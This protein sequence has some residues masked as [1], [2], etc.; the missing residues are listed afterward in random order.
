[1]SS[2]SSSTPR[3]T[4]TYED[5][6]A[7]LSQ[8]QS[9]RHIVNLFSSQPDTAQQDIN[10]L[11]IPEM[12]AWLARAG[13]PTPE[14]LSS[15]GLKVVHV[16]GTKGKGSV[17]ALVSGI[18]RQYAAAGEDE[19]EV[20]V[21]T[22]VS[23]HVVDVR[24]RILLNGEVIG[25]DK[26]AKYFFEVWERLSRAAREAGDAVPDAAGGG[27]VPD[28]ESERE[29]WYDGAATKPFY[30]RFLT[31]LAF[32]IFVS[33]PGVRWA[34]VE[35]GIGGEYDSTNVLPAEMVTAAVVTQLGVDHVSMLGDTVPK[36]AWH[37]AGIFKEGVRGFTRE[38]KETKEGEEVMEVLR[39]RA[40]EKGAS[41]LV[42]VKDEEVE[43][44]RGVQG[45]KLE[46]PFQKYNMA[47]AVAAAREH[48]LKVG[49]RLDGEFAETGGLD[50]MP[51]EFEKGLREASL[52]GRCEVLKDEEG[53]EW[54]VDGAHTEDSLRGVGEWFAG[55]VR[56]GEDKAVR[57]LV[58]NQQDRDPTVLVRALL[59]GVQGKEGGS[60]RPV[61]T[62]AVFTRNEEAPP[63]DGEAERDL[64]I[65]TK[66][67]DTLLEYFGS[68]KG[69]VDTTVRNAVQPT[70]E[71]VRSIARHAKEEGKEC[72]VLVTGSFHLLGAVLKTIDHVEL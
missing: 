53:V 63:A 44:W 33:E 2:S 14:S 54:F 43:R 7:L 47:L 46:G 9:N 22:Y 28:E 5:A 11:A 8:L 12:R 15:S 40:E 27:G 25:K 1:M 34:V 61:F 13:Y 70:I 50:K 21:G 42:E 20:V 60:T 67:R 3:P 17:S 26:F 49:V 69:E 45:A 18:L 29:A 72:K 36:I 52:K 39:T 62:H 10:S 38:L 71:L 4:K 51:V 56:G 48:L 35:C 66:A 23:P 57:V 41:G 68:M 16:A 24:E 30:F 19:G 37:K 31:I 32:H 6:L 55:K 58:F 64:G 59:D 65:Q